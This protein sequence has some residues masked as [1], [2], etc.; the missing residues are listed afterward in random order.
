MHLTIGK[1]LAALAVVGTVATG[2]V[3]AVGYRSLSQAGAAGARQVHAA[4]MLRAANELDMMHDALRA[5]VLFAIA[6]KTP[7]ERTSAKADAVDHSTTMTELVATLEAGARTDEMSRSVAGIKDPTSRYME[8]TQALTADLAA[9]TDIGDRF[10]AYM[11]L[12]RELEDSLANNSDLVVTEMQAAEANGKSTISNAKLTLLVA[13]VLAMGALFTLATVIGRG[14]VARVRKCREA[15][16]R[17]AD[18]DLTGTVDDDGSDEIADM[19]R[20][21]SRTVEVLRVTMSDIS[22]SAEALA[23]AST[24]LASVS[25]EVGAGAESTV[26]KVDSVSASSAEVTE[27]VSSV[28]VGTEELGASIREISRS[29][30]EAAS[31]A[32]AAVNAAQSTTETVGRLGESS[33]DIVTV[34]N[35]ITSIAE[36]T[37]LLAL[38]ATIEAARAGEAGRGF[39][40]VANEVK[41]LAQGTARATEEIRHKVDAIRTVSTAAVDA[42]T[43]IA[44]VVHQINDIQQTIAS[45]VEEQSATTDVISQNVSVAAQGAAHITASIGEVASTAERASIAAT[46]TSRAADEMRRLSEDLRRMVGEFVMR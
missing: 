21:V 35:T 31:V 23:G 39:A 20:A 24:E 5:D 1:K 29:A 33:N 38:N 15:I 13:L 8:Q 2:T 30:N 19:M 17:L 25:T 40:V 42:I 28:A 11:D 44:T 18:K 7:D 41:E 3:A 10:D 16:L 36:Q 43:E 6:A 27:N 46:D 34:I 45:A 9:G 14:I 12:F 32:T 26:S 37:N 22:Q 4:D